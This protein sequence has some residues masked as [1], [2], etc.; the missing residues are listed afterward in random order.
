MLLEEHRYVTYWLKSQG[1]TSVQP[2]WAVG[3]LA[4]LHDSLVRIDTDKHAPV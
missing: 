4:S 3:A 1:A 2:L